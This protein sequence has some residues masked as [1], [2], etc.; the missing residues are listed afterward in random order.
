MVVVVNYKGWEAGRFCVRVTK[1]EWSS[2]TVCDRVSVFSS[3]PLCA[4]FYS[5]G[6]PIHPT[7][8]LLTAT[9]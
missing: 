8:E 9:L 6:R 5:T 7:L 4:I 1:H 3:P 2:V